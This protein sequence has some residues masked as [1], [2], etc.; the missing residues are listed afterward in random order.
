MSRG[1]SFTGPGPLPEI[2]GMLPHQRGPRG[3]NTRRRRILLRWRMKLGGADRLE[4]DW[5]EE[6]LIRVSP[7]SE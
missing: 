1:R 6:D 2:H 7:A 5:L 3:V 4:D